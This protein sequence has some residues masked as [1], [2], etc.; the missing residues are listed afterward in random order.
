MTHLGISHLIKTKTLHYNC[1][2][3][4]HTKSMK[5]KIMSHVKKI[6][7]IFIFAFALPL[8]TF[9]AINSFALGE[10]SFDKGSFLCGVDVSGLTLS[11]AENKINRH[12]T[13][14]T[15]T[16]IYQDKS[17]TIKKQDYTS[18][19]KVHFVLDAMEKARYKNNL[20]K[21]K[22]I[23]RI[24]AMGFDSKIASEYALQE[25]S[26]QIESIEKEINVPPTNAKAQY[27]FVKNALDF[28]P[29]KY[30][31]AIDK[32]ALYEDIASKVGQNEPIEIK[33][34]AIRPTFCKEDLQRAL[35]L[36]AEFSTDYVSSSYERKNNIKLAVSALNNCEILP[37]EEFSFNDI[38]GKRTLDK[39][40][41]EANII[42]D[43][44]F[45]K[46][47]G[48]GVCQVSTTLYNALLLSGIDVTEAHKHTLPV[49]YVP[50]ALD[51]MVSWGSADLKFTNKTNLPIYIVAQANGQKITF[52]IFGDTKEKNVTL[53]TR[54]QI[55]TKIPA[56]DMV[57]K[58]TSG[59]YADKIMFKG[60]Y[61][62]VKNAKDGFE[63]KSYLEKY[64]NGVLVDTKELRHAI[65]E[66]QNGIVYEGID[67]LPEGM[68]LPKD[69]M[70]V[71][72]EQ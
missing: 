60:E 43:G 23:K 40:Y 29:E 14:D 71:K 38:I 44:T 5:I 25:L 46:G 28:I 65:Y 27:N 67:S 37:N 31:L 72:L 58:D 12:L 59:K 70:T 15:L 4:S 42:K 9:W 11:Q 10:R 1:R 51:A 35:T 41:K 53:K 26:T 57:F 49:S 39:G 33:A 66:P 19:S 2:V 34:T 3:F 50:P 63:A 32:E 16:L 18:Q 68:R 64:I 24:K 13:D 56:K 17:W 52:K 7:I 6:F 21:N 30:G 47:V 20:E 69:K 48:G 8:I 61:L 54:S 22:L 55:I 45:V 36:Q 62:R